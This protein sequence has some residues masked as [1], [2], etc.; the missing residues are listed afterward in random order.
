MNADIAAIRELR[1]IELRGRCGS[2]SR[3]IPDALLHSPDGSLLRHGLVAA[4]AVLHPGLGSPHDPFRRLYWL[5]HVTSRIWDIRLGRRRGRVSDLRRPL[6]PARARSKSRHQ[7]HHERFQQCR[8]AH[9]QRLHQRENVL[10]A[11]VLVECRPG[12]T[13]LHLLFSVPGRD[14]IR[15]AVRRW[16]EE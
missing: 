3:A 1:P 6:L 7:F 4:R 16:D 2:C 13:G 9:R 11:G 5:H 14:G 10:A 12:G 8:R 15:E